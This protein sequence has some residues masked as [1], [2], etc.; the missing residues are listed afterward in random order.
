MEPRRRVQRWILALAVLGVVSLVLFAFGAYRDRHHARSVNTLMLIVQL[1]TACDQY[2]LRHGA[3]PPTDP[4]GGTREV[5]RVLGPRNPS[6]TD[7]DAWGRPLRYRVDARGQVEL[8][9][10][11]PDGIFDSDDDVAFSG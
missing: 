11:G 10:A 9:S 5:L 3:L 7:V 8:R 2:K 6:A 1:K 4:D